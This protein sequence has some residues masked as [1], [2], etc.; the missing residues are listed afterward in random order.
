MALSHRSVF[1]SFTTLEVTWMRVAERMSAP[2]LIEQGFRKRAGA[3][4]T[5]PITD[6]VLG[7]LALNTATKYEPAGQVEVNPI[8]GI[9][10]RQVEELVARLCEE[11]PHAYMPATAR[12]PI[13]YIMPGRRYVTW[14][15][16]ECAPDV[17]REMVAAIVE[18]GLPFM[19]DN[20]DLPALLS[21]LESGHFGPANQ[22][23]YRV[24]AIWLLLGD[25]ERAVSSADAFLERLGGPRDQW[26]RQYR[27]FVG[28]LRVEA[29]EA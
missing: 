19:G 16:N 11:K 1:G 12:T 22:V 21:L 14:T 25:I 27:A 23:P 2:L 10:H 28:A 4:F 15:M 18:Y 8:V 17:A 24:P 6:D 20:A 29:S 26:T 3:I 9:R 7:W 5:I 13:G